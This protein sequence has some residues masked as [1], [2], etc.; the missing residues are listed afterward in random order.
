MSNGQRQLK[1]LVANRGKVKCCGQSTMTVCLLP[2]NT[3]ME[4]MLS[5]LMANM[6]HVRRAS[7]VCDPFVGSGQYAAC[8]HF[9]T[10]LAPCSCGTEMV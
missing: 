3:S 1:P 4:P 5:M 7:L 8:V 6:A 9:M 10:L 2:A